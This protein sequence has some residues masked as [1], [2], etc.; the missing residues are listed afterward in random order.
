MEALL[1]L[2]QLRW[3]GHVIRM[4]DSR[5]PKQTFYGQLHH[6]SSRSGGQHKRYKDRLKDTLK[7]CGITPSN[8]EKP[9][10]GQNNLAAYYMP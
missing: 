1:Q 3:C 10:K 9:G 4:D 5:I 8:L 7:Q 6:G 2:S